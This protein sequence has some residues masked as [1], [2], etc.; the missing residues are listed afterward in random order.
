MTDDLEKIRLIPALSWN[1]LGGTEE[2]HEKLM[3]RA[4]FEPRFCRIKA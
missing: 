1:L 4:R 2:R 3:S